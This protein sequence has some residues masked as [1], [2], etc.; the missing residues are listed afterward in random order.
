MESKI[1]PLGY[2]TGDALIEIAAKKQTVEFKVC[3]REH[4]FLAKLTKEEAFELGEDL[5]SAAYDAGL[6]GARYE[7]SEADSKRLEA[8]LKRFAMAHGCKPGD[9][10]EL[11]LSKVI[12][13][14]L[15]RSL[16]F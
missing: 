7:V 2:S 3:Y 9:C 5:I 8:R 10:R 14:G 13:L 16:E 11:F 12:A 4:G 15:E 1:V 6:P